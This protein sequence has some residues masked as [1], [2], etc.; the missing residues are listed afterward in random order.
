MTNRQR[1]MVRAGLGWLVLMLPALDVRAHVANEVI[2]VVND[3][4][5]G[6]AHEFTDC[7]IALDNQ[8]AA[9][10][11]NGLEV[12]CDNAHPEWNAYPASSR[13]GALVYGQV[14]VAMGDASRSWDGCVQA[15][16]RTISEVVDDRLQMTTEISV[17]CGLRT[18][19]ARH[20]PIVLDGQ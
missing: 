8:G 13:A 10:S 14:V 1:T 16:R 4:A 19:T 5:T 2:L 7:R 6:L 20:L 9:A 15:F 11:E 17:N 12:V 18:M 3:Y